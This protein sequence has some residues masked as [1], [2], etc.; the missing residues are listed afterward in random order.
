MTAWIANVVAVMNSAVEGTP[1]GT[2]AAT[3]APSEVYFVY[4]LVY[5]VVGIFGLTL[6]RR[7]RFGSEHR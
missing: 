1:V 4:V 2:P 7:L 6:I 3:A 5:V